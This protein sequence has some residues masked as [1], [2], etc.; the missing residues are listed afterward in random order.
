M[1]VPHPRGKWEGIVLESSGTKRGGGIA[2]DLRGERWG[3]VL[4]PFD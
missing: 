3:L 2:V 4:K 1:S